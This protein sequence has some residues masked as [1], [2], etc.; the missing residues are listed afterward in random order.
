MI[1][2]NGI[3]KKIVAW[4]NLKINIYY[5]IILFFILIFFNTVSV[6]QTVESETDSVQSTDT[7]TIIAVG[8]IMLGSNF[9]TEEYLPPDDNCLPLMSPLFDTL[10][11]ADITFGN[12]EGCFLDSGKLVKNCKD[13]TKCYAFRMPDK[14]ADCLDSAGFDLMS[15]A[16]NHSGDFGKAGR[17]NSIRLL[18][19]RNIKVA[20]LEELTTAIIERNGYKIGLCA[21]SPNKGTCDINIVPVAKKIVKYLDDSCDI[22]IA[23]FHGGAE[24][25]DYQHVPRE[26]EMFYGEDR[27]DVYL[28]ARQ[29]IDA[30]ADAVFGHGPHV[31]RAIDYYKGRFIIYSLGNFCTYKRFNLRGPNGIAP[32][33]KLWLS[34][35]GELYKAQIIPVY[36]GK[37]VGVR[38]DPNARVLNKI[39]QLTRKDIPELK[40]EIDENGIVTFD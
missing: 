17:D 14:Y 29:L 15:M 31:T 40:F 8:D 39:E 30:G 1:I 25:A 36:Q 4:V 18:L 33:I 32:I 37:E 13:T 11:N 10:K 21:F 12:L 5:L 6:A 34:T 26:H 3:K 7:I 19:E 22:V 16:N 35:T 27:G 2:L 24:G 23:S 28:F 20:G 38:Y 9:P